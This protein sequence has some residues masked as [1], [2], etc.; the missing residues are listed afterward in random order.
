MTK[1]V[2]SDKVLP[3]E[4]RLAIDHRIRAAINGWM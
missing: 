1:Y 4:D 3:K 2:Q